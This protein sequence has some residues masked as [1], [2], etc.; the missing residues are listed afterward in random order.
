MDKRWVVH[1]YDP[2]VP[3]PRLGLVFLAYLTLFYP[4]GSYESIPKWLVG[5]EWW[6]DYRMRHTIA[7]CERISHVK[8]YTARDF[9]KSTGSVTATVFG[10]EM[11]RSL[12]VPVKTEC[13]CAKLRTGRLLIG[14][15][16]NNSKMFT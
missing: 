13:A 11:R 12:G 15:V 5:R 3:S 16:S 8:A 1:S 14:Q 9:E 10:E 6:K 2:V 4:V 7:G